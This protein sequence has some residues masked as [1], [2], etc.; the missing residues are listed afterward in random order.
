MQQWI[1]DLTTGWPMIRANLPTFLVIVV[2]IIG[3][4][5]WV[6]ELRYGVIVASKTSQ[7]ELQDRQLADYKQKLDGASPDQAKAK[8]EALEKTISVSNPPPSTSSSNPAAPPEKPEPI[9]THR[10]TPRE[11]RDFI[12]DLPKLT[13]ILNAA[14]NN[15]SSLSDFFITPRAIFGLSPW[16]KNVRQMG[17]GVAMDRLGAISKQIEADSTS[18]DKFAEGHQEFSDV[19]YKLAGRQPFPHRPPFLDSS[20]PP[21]IGRAHV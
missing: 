16:T 6:M 12:D 18:Y 7:I 4:L 19:L 1:Q 10:Y 13:A 14:S 17:I 11:S 20:A 8:I 2:L 3:A 21:E 15:V 5:W 9:L